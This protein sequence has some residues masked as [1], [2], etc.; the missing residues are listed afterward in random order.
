M[1]VAARHLAAENPSLRCPKETVAAVEA[2]SAEPQLGQ[3][4]GSFQPRP[5]LT[6]DQVEHLPQ[7]RT[8]L[9]QVPAVATW[10]WSLLQQVQREEVAKRFGSE[11]QLRSTM[12]GAQ[13]QCPPPMPDV[14]RACGVTVQP[15][16]W[17]QRRHPTFYML[18]LGCRR[19]VW[20][21]SAM[22]SPRPGT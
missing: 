4:L 15:L 13:I 9:L 16:L 17:R 6:A 19:L 1:T 20:T 3:L 14:A 2:E 18:G 5:L 8:A 21:S 7:R 22:A 11:T 10:P 12:T